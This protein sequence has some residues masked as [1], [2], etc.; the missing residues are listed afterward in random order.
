MYRQSI[1]VV[2]LTIL[3]CYP[4]DAQA[5]TISLTSMQCAIYRLGPDVVSGAASIVVDNGQTMR[6]EIVSSVS[7]LV[8]AIETPSG[9][10][11]HAN[12]IGLCGGEYV[13]F[14]GQASPG[15]LIVPTDQP[16]FHYVYLLP[17][18][19]WGTYTLSFQAPMPLLQD[20]AVIVES[21]TDSSL[22]ASLINRS[23][24]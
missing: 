3:Y 16:G 11:I 1:A 18:Q 9:Q 6:I 8:T 17:S 24:K 10:T 23:I 21:L 13:S 7:S 19:G 20:A 14:Q 12:D 15:L 22:Q 2:T 5:E 4:I